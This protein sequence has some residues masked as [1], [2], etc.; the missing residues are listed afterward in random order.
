MINSLRLQTGTFPRTVTESVA[1]TLIRQV[2][3]I[4]LHI[5]DLAREQGSWRLELNDL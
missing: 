2:A 1:E 4:K 3:L 5:P